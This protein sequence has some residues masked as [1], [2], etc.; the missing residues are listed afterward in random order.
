MTATTTQ[1]PNVIF[2]T[3]AEAHQATKKSGIVRAVISDTS[4]D[5]FR[6]IFDSHG[7]EWE[8]YKDAGSPIMWE[9]GA[10]VERARLP[11]GNCVE[12]PE[13]V[14]FRGVP[15]IVV[16][17]DFWDDEFS[18]TIAK[19]YRSGK[20]KSWSIQARPIEESP[21]TVTERRNAEYAEATTVYRRWELLEAS[22]VSIAGNKN[23]LTT[24]VLRSL[25]GSHSS[26]ALA[27][28]KARSAIS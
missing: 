12:G 18:G 6:T 11:I 5:R 19:A 7:C 2:R 10:S 9:H 21:P 15:S 27:I 28:T 17:V 1:A 13:R 20:M 14:K 25:S 8:A 24:E 26:P 3:V 16:G 22:C 23:C 4:L